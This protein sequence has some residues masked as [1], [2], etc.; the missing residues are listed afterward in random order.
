MNGLLYKGAEMQ[1]ADEKIVEGSD[2]EEGG[3]DL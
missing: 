3:K 2:W 1:L